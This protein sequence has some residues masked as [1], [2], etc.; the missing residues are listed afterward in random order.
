VVKIGKHV[1]VSAKIPKELKEEIRAL[2]INPSKVIREALEN[3]VKK[4]KI[5]K[6]L[7]ELENMKNLLTQPD[8]T[9]KLIRES[10]DER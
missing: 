4:K 7:R 1:T 9:V 8:E 6:L 10:R 3:E 2:K 5:E